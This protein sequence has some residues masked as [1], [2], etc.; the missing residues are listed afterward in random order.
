M[1]KLPVINAKMIRDLNAQKLA[2]SAWTLLTLKAEAKVWKHYTP[3]RTSEGFAKVY[4]ADAAKWLDEHGITDHSGFKIESTSAP[5]TDFY[6]ARA[7]EIAVKGFSSLPSVKEVRERMDAKEPAKGKKK[8]LTPSM[9]LMVPA[10]CEVDAFLASP[11]YANAA[12]KEALFAKWVGDKAQAT[13]RETRKLQTRMAMQS[14]AITVGGTWLFE[15]FDETTL[16]V[17]LGGEPRDVV[18][19]LDESRKIE[20]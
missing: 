18:F 1:K 14:W 5:P 16:K 2:E 9:K 19:K 20:V 13:V 10:L 7:F 15:S 8:E 3:E 17:T 4:G 11:I 12:D 6:T